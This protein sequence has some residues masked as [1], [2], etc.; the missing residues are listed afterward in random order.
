MTKIRIALA[1]LLFAFLAN[2]PVA[3]AATTVIGFDDI[4]EGTIA[5]NQYHGVIFSGAAVLTENS[6]LN[7]PFP[8]KSDPNVVFNYLD[9]TSTLDFT[10]SGVT[11][12]GAYV[13]GTTAITESIFSGATLLGTTATPGPNYI[14]AGS[15]SPNI[16]LSLSGANITS[17]VFANL[18]GQANTFTLDDVTI[19][20]GDIFLN[21]V[22]LP[23]ALPLFGAALAG[24]ASAGWLLRRRRA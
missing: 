6:L 10:V 1:A 19:A 24:L 9:G 12:I 4:P 20:G 18:S 22:P 13:T 17:A 16:F 23:P 14:G 8:P 5:S 11:S 21:P 2:A 15:L 7:P 3:H